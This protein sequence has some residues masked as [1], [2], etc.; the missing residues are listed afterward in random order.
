MVGSMSNFVEIVHVIISM[1]ILPLADSR[2]A[3]VSYQ[4]KYVH[5]Y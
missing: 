5:K 4:W 3:D 2:R 1:V